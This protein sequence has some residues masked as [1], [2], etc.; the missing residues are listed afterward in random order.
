MV[1]L[2]WSKIQCFIRELNI[3]KSNTNTIREKYEEKVFDLQ[4]VNTKEQLADIMTKPLS[5]DLFEAHRTRL[6]S[7]LL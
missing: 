7:Y 6:C 3:L 5:R 4:F 1:H 2:D